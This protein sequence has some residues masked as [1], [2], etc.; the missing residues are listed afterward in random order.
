MNIMKNSVHGD[1]ICFE[2]II[3]MK[4]KKINIQPTQYILIG[5]LIIIIFG[6]VLL[7]LPVSSADGVRV[8]YIDALFTA[9][10]ASCVTGLVTVPTVSAWSTFGHVVILILIQIGGFGVVGVV[11]WFMSA[12]HRKADLSEH[13]RISE[14]FN[15]NTLSGLSSFVKKVVY[16]TFFVEGI[17]ALM[18]MPVFVRD[19]GLKGIWIAVFNSV[20]AFC[21]AGIDIIAPDS[22]SRYA[23]DPLVNLTTCLLITF[24]GIGYV[25]WWDFIRVFKMMRGQKRKRFFSRLTLHSKIAL[26]ASAVLIF[27]GALGFFIFEYDNPATIGNFS[28]FGKI[29]ASFFQS[30]T[31]RTAGFFTVNQKDLTPASSFL[32]LILMFI[33]GSPVGT[34]GGIKTVTA[35]VL[36][37]TAFSVIKNKNST[38]IFNRKIADVYIKKAAAVTCFSF[39]TAFVSTVLL[40]FVSSGD[41]M[42]VIYETVSAA[43][44][45]GLSRDFTPTLSVL[46]KIIVIVTMYFGRVGPVSF[47]VALTGRQKNSNSVKNPEEEISVG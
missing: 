8:K 42:D 30:V 45:V 16:G 38:D 21:N 2:V 10:T 7:S 41:P 34:A 17:G 22:L 12:A 33:G 20:S 23:L 47:A 28:L 36:V 9:A 43:A 26:T 1:I 18:Y 32:S 3:M 6:S 15:L 5:F 35:A 39:I 27:S 11:S 13:I 4:R 19:F 40:A 14:A 44:T 31:T 25:V 29:Q 24:G 37:S 46:G